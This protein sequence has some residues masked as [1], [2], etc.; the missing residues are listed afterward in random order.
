MSYAKRWTLA[1]SLGRP[2]PDPRDTGAEPDPA[3]AQP[4]I[5]VPVET[6]P[7]GWATWQPWAL[8]GGAAAAGGL[9]G[10]L[11]AERKGAAIGAAVVGVGSFA[12]L[13]SGRL[14]QAVGG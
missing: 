3:V 1:V 13:A 5:F 7:T 14:G 8:V 11:V 2:Y 10:Y 6:R 9:L 12:L 4:P